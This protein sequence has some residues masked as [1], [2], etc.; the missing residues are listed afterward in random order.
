MAQEVE[1]A[2]WELYDFQLNPRLHM[3]YC[4]IVLYEDTEPLIA[5]EGQV[6]VTCMVCFLHCR[7]VNV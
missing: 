7:C 2:A 5:S 4:G 6:Y 3:G 1:W